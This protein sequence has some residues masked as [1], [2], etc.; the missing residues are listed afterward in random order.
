MFT[1]APTSITNFFAVVPK[2]AGLAVIIRFM[3]LPLKIFLKNGK[4]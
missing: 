2:A 1:R 4:L 3:D